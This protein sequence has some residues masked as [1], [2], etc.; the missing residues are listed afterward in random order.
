[1][2]AL[3][4]AL[5]LDAAQESSCS[6]CDYEDQDS[7]GCGRDADR[8]ERNRD[9]RARHCPRHRASNEQWV[10]FGQRPRLTLEDWVKLYGSNTVLMKARFVPEAGTA[11]IMMY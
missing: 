10:E 11:N 8:P 1:M 6:G 9:C 7:P 2:Q 5:C 4:D 3:A